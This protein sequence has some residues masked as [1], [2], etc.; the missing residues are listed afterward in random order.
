MHLGPQPP[1]QPPSASKPTQQP[2]PPPR[3]QFRLVQIQSPAPL[4]QPLPPPTPEIQEEWNRIGLATAEADT[5][6]LQRYIAAMN[7]DTERRKQDDQ[8]QRLVFQHAIIY[9]QDSNAWLTCP[10][11]FCVL[12]R[13]IR[14]YEGFDQIGQ[15]VWE[16]EDYMKCRDFLENSDVEMCECGFCRGVVS[17]F[18]NGA[19][20]E[21]KENINGIN[22]IPRGSNHDQKENKEVKCGDGLVK[23]VRDLNLDAN[24]DRTSLKHDTEKRRYSGVFDP[25][26]TWPFGSIY[27]STEFDESNSFATPIVRVESRHSYM[28]HCENYNKDIDWKIENMFTGDQ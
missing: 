23:E 14:Q 28:F 27:G 25:N 5:H 7:R 17:S 8:I 16:D 15:R 1:I 18:R 13:Y 2:Q 20:G 6:R 26:K 21:G 10:C 12:M 19:V 24:C 3:T 9:R 22:F 4:R 11:N